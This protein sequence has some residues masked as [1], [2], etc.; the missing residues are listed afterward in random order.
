[1]SV[2]TGA[3]RSARRRVRQGIEA[4]PDDIR[5][6]A[7]ALATRTTSGPTVLPGPPDGPVLVVAPHPD[8]E[9]IGPGATLARHAEEG[10]EVRVLVCTS[11]GATAG[12]GMDVTQVREEESRRALRQLGVDQPPRFGRLTDGALPEEAAALARLIQ[13]HGRDVAT[14]Y[15]P[16]LLDHHPDHAAAAR[17]L[18]RT[19]LPDEVTVMGYEVWAAAPVNV[20]LDVTR[21]FAR[22]QAALGEYLV[23]LET[24]DYVRSASG[25]AAYRSAEGAL[26]G[27]GF[28][29][30]FVQ[31]SLAEYRSW[32]NLYP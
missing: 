31:S 20:L 16:S 28:A 3:I 29:E 30:G 23:A 26:G 18:A 11:G 9:V 2:P 19:D 32:V 14:V 24:V 1:M 12:G 8:D 4:L 25:L 10:H 6:L 7:L 13:E 21:V 5:E 22:K 17:A 27:R 15:V